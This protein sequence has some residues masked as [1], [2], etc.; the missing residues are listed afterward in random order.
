MKDCLSLPGL[1]RKFF[2]SIITEECEPFYTYAG[3]YMIW[4]VREGV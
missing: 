3:K 1:G 2:N 4:F